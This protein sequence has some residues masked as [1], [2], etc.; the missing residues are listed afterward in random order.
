MYPNS[1]LFNKSPFMTKRTDIIVL[2]NHVNF[3]AKTLLTTHSLPLAHA[4]S[5]ILHY[6][7]AAAWVA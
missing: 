6:N 1:Y 5:L 7:I 2:S 4:V 3:Q